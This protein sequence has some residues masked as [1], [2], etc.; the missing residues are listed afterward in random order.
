[1][2]LDMLTDYN[3][4][5]GSCPILDE[6]SDQGKEDTVT[7]GGPNKKTEEESEENEECNNNKKVNKTD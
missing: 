6:E 1:M 5:N 3:K 4:Y 2:A 7:G